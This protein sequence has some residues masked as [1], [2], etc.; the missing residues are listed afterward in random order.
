MHVG[1]RVWLCVTSE[2]CHV[3]RV[4]PAAFPAED[5]GMLVL[6]NDRV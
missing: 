1:N 3:G 6:Y 4:L 2:T 5:K